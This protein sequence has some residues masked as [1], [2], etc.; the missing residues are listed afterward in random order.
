MVV[1]MVVLSPMVLSTSAAH[2]AIPSE[3]G[4]ERPADPAA[5]GITLGGFKFMTVR[6]D[7]DEVIGRKGV[8][9]SS[10][11]FSM[12]RRATTDWS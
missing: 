2:F 12:V 10:L 9:G 1:V 6:A 11:G 5:K 4:E 8:S 3:R 7:A